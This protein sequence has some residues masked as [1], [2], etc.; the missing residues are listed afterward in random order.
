[1]KHVLLVCVHKMKCMRFVYIRVVAKA[2]CVRIAV[3]NATLRGVFVT[4][5]TYAFKNIRQISLHFFDDVY[6]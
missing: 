1:M 5:D 6:G 3:P 4:Y 2:T